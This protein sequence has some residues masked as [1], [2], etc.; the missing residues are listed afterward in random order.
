MWRNAICTMLI[1][2]KNIKIKKVWKLKVNYTIEG[3]FCFWIENIPTNTFLQK[4]SRS[5]KVFPC[6][7]DNLWN[8]FDSN[9]TVLEKNPLFS[10]VTSHQKWKSL[11]NREYFFTCQMD[12]QKEEALIAFSVFLNHTALVWQTENGS[13]LMTQMF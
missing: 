8:T 10:I 7:F 6:S 3:D 12:T 11:A 13:G 1:R 2:Y 5:S 9:A 4:W